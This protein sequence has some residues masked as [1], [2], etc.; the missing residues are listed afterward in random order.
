MFMVVLEILLDV[1]LVGSPDKCAALGQIYLQDAKTWGMSRAV[2]DGQSSRKIKL[3]VVERLPVQV[4]AEIKIIATGAG[5]KPQ[6]QKVR[7]SA[8]R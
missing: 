7:K 8:H 2:I 1:V 4:S 3:G 5:Q 6:I